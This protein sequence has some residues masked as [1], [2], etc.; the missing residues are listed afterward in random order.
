MR[1][2]KNTAVLFFFHAFFHFSLFFVRF[3]P[4][5]SHV[6]GRSEKTNNEK[7]DACVCIRGCALYIYIRYIDIYIY[8][9]WLSYFRFFSRLFLPS[10]THTRTHT[11]KGAGDVKLV[12][13]KMKWPTHRK[14]KIHERKENARKRNLHEDGKRQENIRR[15]EAKRKNTGETI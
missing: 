4:L 14:K 15:N 10:K 5:V 1:D 12:R 3:L 13:Q 6:Q 9:L 7:K 11:Y 8:I 2:K